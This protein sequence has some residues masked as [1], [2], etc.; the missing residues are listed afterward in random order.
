M[1]TL[2]I[3]KRTQR[4]RDRQEDCRARHFNPLLATPSERERE[5]ERKRER[6]GNGEGGGRRKREGEREGKRERGRE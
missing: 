2:S 5:R 3:N 6:K 1:Q 4:G